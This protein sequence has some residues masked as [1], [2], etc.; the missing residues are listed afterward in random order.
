MQP[1]RPAS[2]ADLVRLWLHA[3]ARAGPMRD[4]RGRSIDVIYPGRR[5]GLPGPD[6]VDAI[7]SIDGGPARRMAV[8]V[9]L[10]EASWHAHGHARDPRYA[11]PLLHLVW[12]R[13]RRPAPDWPPHILAPRALAAWAAAPGLPAAA[14]PGWPCQGQPQ[15]AARAA[16]L[17]AELRAQ[18]QRRF[19][20]RAAALEGDVEALGAEQALHL[21][22]LRTLGATANVRP[23]AAVAA[24]APAALLEALRGAPDGARLPRVEAELL[25]AAGL[26]PS[27]RG[28]PAAHPHLAAL[29]RAWTLRGPR[30]PP[31]GAFT[32]A[33]VRPANW[34]ARRLAGAARILSAPPPAEGAFAAA[35]ETRVLAAAAGG[36]GAL[37]RWFEVP[38]APQDFWAGHVDA[39]RPS[40]RPLRALI[41]RS[42]A[43]ELLVNAALPF[44]AALGR[45]RGDAR[46]ARAA[47]QAFAALAGGG[48]NRHTRYVAGVLRLDA[49]GLSAPIAQQGLLRLYRRWCRDKRC[50]ECPAA[51]RS[52]RA[53]SGQGAAAGGS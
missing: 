19:D 49:R 7:V 35:L 26:L 45:R 13:A 12:A 24:A 15:D 33:A 27:Q 32:L 28:L 11:A 53:A 16:E 41:G 30:P 42:C 10:D 3:A 20:E 29:E 2:E 9:H 52:G 22:L 50:Q 40:S 34:P 8:E 25:G 31:V 5:T 46:L 18:G 1:E 4:S 36:A 39:G 17:H 21:A 23:F 6:L 37:R 14:A 51:A 47:A 43:L 48:W 44:A 38:L